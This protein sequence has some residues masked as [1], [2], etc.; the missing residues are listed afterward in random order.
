M[1]TRRLPGVVIQGDSLH[2]L[3]ED[4]REV[5]GLLNSGDGP[6]AASAIGG[7]LERLDDVL[8]HYEAVLR[9]AGYDLPYGSS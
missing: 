8:A 5:A 1:P 2:I 9:R 4:I 7:V 6:A 3:R